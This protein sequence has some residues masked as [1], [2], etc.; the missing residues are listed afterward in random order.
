MKFSIEDFLGKCEQ[1][2][3][4]V[5]QIWW[6]V[7][8]KNSKQLLAIT[9]IRKSTPSQI[10]HKDIKTPLPPEHFTIIKTGF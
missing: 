7:F 4:P 2:V 10:F 6:V 3:H 1:A 9:Y 8:F 5:K